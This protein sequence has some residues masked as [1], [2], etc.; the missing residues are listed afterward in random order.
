MECPYCHGEMKIGYLC[1]SAP[2]H[3]VYWL[4]VEAD[5][6][7]LT[8]W[9][10]AK[11]L[12]ELGGFLIDKPTSSTLLYWKEKPASYRCHDCNILLTKLYTEE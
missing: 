8:G 6:S 4:P 12:E 1:S 5:R 9:S 2:D 10:R 3:A 7:R 11:V